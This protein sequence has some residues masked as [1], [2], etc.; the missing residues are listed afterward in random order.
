MAGN[1]KIVSDPGTT[2]YEGIETVYDASATAPE[3][4]AT[5]LENGAISMPATVFSDEAGGEDAP[6]PGLSI[7]KDD[8]I[9]GTYRVE[10]DAIEGGMGAVWRV[11]H[12][13]WDTDLAMKRPQPKCFVS[14]R[15][16][17]NFIHECEAW[18]NL[19][20]HPNIV[21]CYYVREIGGTPS[22][23]S[24]WMDGGSLEN[25]I[26][27]GALY[28][29]S[30]A[31]QQ[32]R[33]LDIAIQFA[34]GLHYAHEAGLIHQDVKPGNLLL[35][36]EGDAKV[37]DFG[38]ARA[39]AMLT[40]PESS[41]AAMNKGADKSK[42]IIAL[43]G[44]CTPAYCSMEQ[45]DGKQ[46]TRR[47][48]IYSWAVSV[49]EMYMGAR[50]WA[51]GVVAGLSC[52]DYFES[53]RLPMPEALQALLAKCME[54]EPSDR[55]HDFAEV[56]K[57]L[58]TIY[59]EETGSA[60]PRPA[61]TAAA[62]TADSLNNRALSF[63][64]LGKTAEAEGCWS[65][66]AAVAPNHMA[67]TW[68]YLLYQW[69]NGRMTDLE[70]EAALI[71]WDDNKSG[72]LSAFCLCRF[73][74]LRSDCQNA[75][76]WL[77][78]ARRRAAEEHP[79]F[80][81][82][83]K[84][85]SALPDLSAPTTYATRA[86]YARAFDALPN[87]ESVVFSKHNLW[88][89][90]SARDGAL[91]DLFSGKEGDSYACA[92]PDQ[93]TL[94]AT[95]ESPYIQDR[96]IQ[97]RI[98][99]GQVLHESCLP[100]NSKLESSCPIT[101]DERH[102]YYISISGDN[103]SLIKWDWQTNKKI[104]KISL[105]DNAVSDLQL[106]A[107]GARI[108]IRQYGKLTLFDGFS[109][110]KLLRLTLN[111]TCARFSPDGRSIFGCDETNLYQW[112]SNSGELLMERFTGVR[113]RKIVFSGNGNIMIG[114]SERT[115]VGVAEQ[116]YLR[117]I[118]VGTGCC[119][120]VPVERDI[121]GGRLCTT[122]NYAVLLSEDFALEERQT[123]VI[124]LPLPDMTRKPQWELC[125]IESTQS[126]ISAQKAIQ[127][128]LTQAR[129]SL[130]E[131]DSERA[132]EAL[133]DCRRLPGF[134]V[135]E[136]FMAVN[137]A[138]GLHE[139]K[140]YLHGAIAGD[141]LSLSGK[142]G[143][144]IY[145]LSISP[146]EKT[147]MVGCCVEKTNS[148]FSQIQYAA[149]QKAFQLKCDGSTKPKTIYS[150][151]W[152][153]RLSYRPERITARYSFNGKCVL[154][155]PRAQ[156]WQ[157]AEN[158]FYHNGLYCYRINAGAAFY[159]GVQVVP[160]EHADEVLYIHE[161]CLYSLAAKESVPSRRFEINGSVEKIL[162]LSPDGRYALCEDFLDLCMLDIW[163]QKIIYRLARIKES[164]GLIMSGF[165]GCGDRFVLA[166]LGGKVTLMNAADG[167]VIRTQDAKM[168]IEAICLVPGNDDFVLMVE[169]KTLRLW[170][171]QRA[172]VAFTFPVHNAN[173][174]SLCVNP[175]GT[176]VFAIDDGGVIC[177]WTLD[178]EYEH[179]AAPL[180]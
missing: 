142:R 101:A 52:R 36:K 102:V 178:W 172:A 97:Y 78:I 60:Y 168:K 173:L 1:D 72:W 39:R 87:E 126:R 127:K 162:A 115:K 129:R 99:D 93:K 166:F 119:I 122:K 45:M 15:A 55:P 130:A 117:F 131:K 28:E 96:I 51:N 134:T 98:A 165:L 160:A 34:R 137:N 143:L 149:V 11:H 145:S 58:Q 33:I 37:A 179:L 158:G 32:E 156:P 132:L 13:G 84:E 89:R 90:W 77:D 138:A 53:A 109:G 71:A 25:A 14:Q 83:E 47:T 59:M 108:A 94:V 148:D 3:G 157:A 118:N 154:S 24:E 147:L 110:E 135:S 163:Q 104:Y 113:F 54:A 124:S 64:D 106:S 66:A 48:D 70:T 171:M 133:R 100:K 177:R 85:I 21:S 92:T 155:S 105:G 146:D 164:S 120:S 79:Q 88:R 4:T 74:I 18:I 49:M 161:N 27:E 50:L 61:P 125:R 91:Q 56:E 2:K 19:G 67:A 121:F 16:K 10:N 170:D 6:A 23:F 43:S 46:L 81:A 41:P 140:G 159:S 29:G 114:Y 8:I 75:R 123:T 128:S 44:G 82:A 116:A 12:I 17:A 111:A 76:R 73:H 112:D 144:K 174:V 107:D 65:A 35:T 20:L 68:N 9:L 176:E 30:E 80:A 40:L 62:D 26:L 180:S 141:R 136:E 57:V 7:Q 69:Q 95:L 63:L 152:K 151:E 38:L 150:E 22:I 175:T 103:R 42:T 86:D 31:A 139:K 153:P 169:G 5:Q 167:S